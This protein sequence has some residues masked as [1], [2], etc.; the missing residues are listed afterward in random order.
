MTQT[1]HTVSELVGL[2]YSDVSAVFLHTS[3]EP[4]II[5]VF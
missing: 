4:I 2:Q 5:S 1:S 3:L